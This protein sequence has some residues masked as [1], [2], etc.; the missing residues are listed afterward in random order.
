MTS[1]AEEC[2]KPR[3]ESHSLLEVVQNGTV[4]VAAKVDSSQKS[5][6]RTSM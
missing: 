6:K 2:A 4:S 5:K 1:E 3:K